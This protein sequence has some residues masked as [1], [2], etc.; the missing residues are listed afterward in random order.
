MDIKTFLNIAPRLPANIAVLIQGPTGIGK[1]YLVR[2]IAEAAELE[3]VDRRLSQMG[4]AASV[5]EHRAR[6]YSRG[7]HHLGDWSSGSG[8]R[9]LHPPAW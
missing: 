4:A 2:D 5:L 7:L 6:A 8:H 1:S 3:V 9:G